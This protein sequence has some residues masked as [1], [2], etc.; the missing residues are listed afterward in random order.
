[1]KNTLN[2]LTLAVCAPAWLVAQ[3]PVSIPG[4]SPDLGAHPFL[5]PIRT[6]APDQGVGGGLWA[7]GAGYKARFDSGVVFYPV[8]GKDAPTNLP[9]RWTTTSVRVGEVAASG[10]LQVA[11][12]HASDWRFELRRGD[13]VEAYDVRD[14]GVEQTFVLNTRPAAGGDLVIEGAIDSELSA[15]A[16]DWRHGEVVFHD[17]DGNARVRYGAAVAIDAHGR[18]TPMETRVLDGKI[19]LRLSSRALAEATFPLTVDPLLAPVA[20]STG[21]GYAGTIG[22]V[23]DD[24]ANHLMVVYRRASAG[25]DYDAFA[26]VID[27]SLAGGSST[28][29]TDIDASWST[30][31]TSG[32]F[33]GGSNKYIIALERRFPA[34]N[35][36]SWIRYHLHAS[37]DLNTDTTVTLVNKPVSET[38]TEPDVGGTASFTTGGRALIAFKSEDPVGAPFYGDVYGMV[39]DTAAN[40]YGGRF[41]LAGAASGTTYDRGG[42]SVN[43]ESDGDGASWVVAFGEYNRA[44]L[45]DDWDVAV[46]R[47]TPAGSVTSRAYIN[48]PTSEHKLRPQVDGRGGRYMLVYGVASPGHIISWMHTLRLNR[49]DFAEGAASPIFRRD[50]LLRTGAELAASDIAY[51]SNSRSHWV[52]GYYNSS[53]RTYAARIGYDSRVLETATLYSGAD[54]SSAPAVCFDNDVRE[55]TVAYPTTGAGYPLYVRKM[56]HPSSPVS[57]SGTGCGG[58]IASNGT[59]NAGSEFFNV[60]LSNAAAGASAVLL[61]SL[62]QADLPLDSIGMTGCHLLVSPANLLFSLNTVTGGTGAASINLPLPSAVAGVDLFFQWAHV[63]LGANPANLRS[64]PRLRTAVR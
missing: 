3:E 48:S 40:T 32:A 28:I 30:D 24:V 51:D 15:A 11:Q 34:N 2:T 10:P 33:V 46:V 9:L 58:V 49:F 16:C 37:A 47:V 35:N 50:S 18:R 56:I 39:V 23:R 6:V 57:V 36:Y 5:S 41:Y 43:K 13:I 54:S 7:S 52:V 31:H 8:L 22:I 42:P 62:G 19:G 53:W 55:F 26:R 21:S 17:S 12:A 38:W 59:S 4:V 20:L 29:W 1:M 64:T 45:S 14:D 25:T 44:A 60:T 63:A 27:D 61:T